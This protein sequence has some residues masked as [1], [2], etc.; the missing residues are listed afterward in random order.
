MPLSDSA[1]K[2]A[3]PQERAYK[4][5]DGE[6]MYL[7]VETNG[8]RLWRMNYRFAGKHKTLAL[9]QYPGVKLV[10]ARQKRTEA[11]RLLAE[12]IDPAEAKKRRRVIDAEDEMSF[13]FVAREWHE[14]QKSRWVPGHQMRVLSRLSDDVFPEIGSRRIDTLEAPE[15]LEM[16][17]KVEGR[18]AVDTARRLRQAIS[19]V[20]RYAIAVGK[21]K[22][23]PASDI[24]GALKVPPRKR[25]YAILKV[26][27]L[28][29]FYERLFAYDGDEAT[30]LAIELVT[31]T[32]VRTAEIIYAQR[33]E[34]EDLGDP[35]KAA[36]R[37]PAARMK[38]GREHIVPLSP[39]A[40]EIVLRLIGLA[41]RSQFLLPGRLG[42]VISKNTMLFALYR[43]GYVG[44]MTVHGLR[45]TASTILN[46]HGFN[47]DWIERQLAHVPGDDVRAAYNAAEWLAERRQMMLWYSDFLEQRAMVARL[48]RTPASITES[49]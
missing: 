1:C 13:E 10:D 34:F 19:G 38:A 25:H 11:R 35:A 16:L 3:K 45:G 37:I 42:G 6:G 21:A 43:M 48:L 26:S 29:D 22:R 12:G 20:F 8:S 46:E 9:G 2:G 5:P 17:R 30:R 39:R 36:W 27:E 31:H 24:R 49:A 32:F 15:I 4:I 40:R 47:R 33:S 44:K 14:N 41:G 28:Q 23:D 7:L 18:G